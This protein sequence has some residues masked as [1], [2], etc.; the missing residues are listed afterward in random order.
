MYELPV[1]TKVFSRGNIRVMILNDSRYAVE[2]EVLQFGI[3]LDR[4]LQHSENL[5]PEIYRRRSFSWGCLNR[6]PAFS[7]I[8]E[9]V[10]TH[11]IS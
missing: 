11:R 7:Y 5:S 2:I 4:I 10:G 8:S 1:Q 3:D 9:S 6:F